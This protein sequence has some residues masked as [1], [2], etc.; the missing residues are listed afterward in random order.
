MSF[1]F[2]IRPVKTEDVNELSEIY[3]HY[4]VTSIATFETEIIS[5]LEMLKRVE[6]NSKKYPWLVLEIQQEIVGYAYAT[7]WK[8]RQAYAQTVESTIY[9]RENVQA[10]G[11]G[12]KLYSSLIEILQKQGLHA[13]LAG[14]SLPNEPSIRLHEKLGFERAGTLKEVGNKFG[15]WIDVGYW[16]LIF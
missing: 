1:D 15:R 9:L 8:T 6:T 2:N 10:K 7:A 4:V 3:N 14:I 5:E 12:Y 16:Q 11:L 13:V